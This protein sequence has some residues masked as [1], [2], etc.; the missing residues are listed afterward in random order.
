MDRDT[1]TR[2]T[3]QEQLQAMEVLWDA[4]AH[5]GVA[6]DSPAWHAEILAIRRASVDDGTA[7]FVT[8]EEIKADHK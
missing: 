8:L 5:S 4:L 6:L 2:M 7:N 3:R 1:I